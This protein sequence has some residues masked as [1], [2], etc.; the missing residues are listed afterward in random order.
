[1]AVG[2]FHSCG[3]TNVGSILCFGDTTGSNATR[4]PSLNKGEVW[5]AVGASWN[6][7]C[8][9][10][11]EGRVMCWG[12]NWGMPGD[13]TTPYNGT[14][15]PFLSVSAYKSCLVSGNNIE[16]QYPEKGIQSIIVTYG[17]PQTCQ[18]ETW[19]MIACGSFFTYDKIEHYCGITNAGSL[20][21]WGDNSF[22]QARV[23]PVA[24]GVSWTSLASSL[25]HVC[26]LT[27]LGEL[28][29]WGKNDNGQT[30]VPG[31]PHGVLWGSRQSTNTSSRPLSVALLSKTKG[32]SQEVPL[33][34]NY[35][36]T[37]SYSTCAI[38]SV[39]G[40]VCW[41]ERRVQASSLPSD[42]SWVSISSARPYESACG[43]TSKRRLVCWGHL[44]SN[45][46]I[47]GPALANERFSV[48]A[49][50][51]QHICAVT[52]NGKMDCCCLNSAGQVDVPIFCNGST[53]MGAS[54]MGFNWEYDV[55][56][57][58]GLSSSSDV[59]CWGTESWYGPSGPIM[60]K[61]HLVFSSSTLPPGEHVI[62]IDGYF[63]LT[64]RGHLVCF[65]EPY[66]GGNF[67]CGSEPQNYTWS[68]ISNGITFEYPYRDQAV[69]CGIMTNGSLV[70]WGSNDFGQTNVPKLPRK[71]K[72]VSV[73]TSGNHTC[74]LTNNRRL[75][76]WGAN[77]NNQLNVPKL[78]KG[79]KWGPSAL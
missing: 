77:D 40:I 73:S 22:H 69:T 41:G 57:T 35:I 21:C 45:G 34:A 6:K 65:K 20:L 66:K 54:V 55:G 24:N 47:V 30:S 79:Q 56:R 48:I 68:A 67:S 19:E 63:G 72:W 52:A 53:W 37:D 11:S 32:S 1:M 76:C 3:L 12:S 42:E 51:A 4:V 59:H 9:V 5:A 78:P 10:T 74:A 75:L 28:L 44:A 58:C 13:F 38:T 8:G 14:F 2:E 25:Y 39:G 27:S 36:M 43:I 61:P 16:Y 33:R 17:L 70:C 46:T 26:G 50:G 18:N 49:A 23:P 29:C 31:L 64:N 7:S 62:L 60:T 15:K 71:E